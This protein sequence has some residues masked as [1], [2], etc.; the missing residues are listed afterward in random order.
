MTYLLTLCLVMF[1]GMGSAMAKSDK[2]DKSGKCG[3]RGKSGNCGIPAQIADLQ[4][5]IDEIELTPGPPGPPGPPDPPGSGGGGGLTPYT[6][7]S[8]VGEPDDDGLIASCGE[9][10][11]IGDGFH[12]LIPEGF[13]FLDDP[14]VITT[15]APVLSG[16]VS[17][18]WMVKAARPHDPEGSGASFTTGY[19]AYA[20]CVPVVV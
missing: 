7:T 9:D 6:V 20:I 2:S 5:Q 17:I 4:A 3:K 12:M 8:E 18:G 10:I 15:S 16:T 11:A 14:A 19:V 13:T 1:V